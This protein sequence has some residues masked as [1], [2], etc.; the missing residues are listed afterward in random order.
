VLTLAKEG[1]YNLDI[2]ISEALLSRPPDFTGIHTC[3][4]NDTLSS[5][6]DAI[7]KT[8]IRRFVVVENEKLVGIVSLSDLLKFMIR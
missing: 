4:R 3:S 5:L 1:Y 8:S 6:L 2:L 7:L